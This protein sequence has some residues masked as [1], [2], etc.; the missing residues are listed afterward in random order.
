[1][2]LLALLGGTVACPSE[3]SAETPSKAPAPLAQ[4]NEPPAEPEP[5]PDPEQ[6]LAAATAK[7]LDTLD[8]LAELHRQHAD[9]C[10]ALAKAI[11][12]FHAEHFG[13]LGDAPNPVLARI[14]ADEALRVR[15][16]GAME[17]IM[18]ASMACRE[19][20]TFAATTVELFGAPA[21]R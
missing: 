14:D 8:A 3:R 19:D 13:E 15:M 11:E 5:A 7:L 18:S 17:A 20:S 10:P 12:G 1:M 21:Q 6:Q 2:A 16:R 4:P 9:D